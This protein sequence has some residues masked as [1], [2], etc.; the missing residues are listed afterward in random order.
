[1]CVAE[2]ATKSYTNVLLNS[3]ES[4]LS[5][6]EIRYHYM[7]EGSLQQGKHVKGSRKNLLDYF[8]SVFPI[9]K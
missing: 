9:F 5:T 7:E 3:I 4:D 2:Q 1:M 8:K 6:C